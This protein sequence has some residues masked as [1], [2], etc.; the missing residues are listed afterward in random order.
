MSIL[1]ASQKAAIKRMRALAW[2]R[3]F[4]VE[5]IA[6]T[7]GSDFYDSPTDVMTTIDLEGD[8][9]W[10]PEMRVKGS[11]GGEF[12]ESDLLLACDIINSGAFIYSGSRLLV[13]GIRCAIV[14]VNPFEDSG[15]VVVA[16]RR[17]ETL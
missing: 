5:Q 2:N 12:G 11:E 13:D 4:T 10:N 15:E 9:T 1:N 3:P 7:V 14:S 17:I 16:A 6:R 8:W